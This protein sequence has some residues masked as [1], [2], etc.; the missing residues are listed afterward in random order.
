M[1]TLEEREQR[2]YHRHQII[3]QAVEAADRIIM[4]VS[5]GSIEESNFLTANVASKIMERALLPFHTE[6]LRKDLE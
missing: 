2:D 4:G 6:I 1:K 5:D 3:Q